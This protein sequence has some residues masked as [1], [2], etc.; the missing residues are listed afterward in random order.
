VYF[1]SGD[2]AVLVSDS[3]E[4]LVGDGPRLC[5]EYLAGALVGDFS[6]QSLTPF[7]GVFRVPA[8]H[9]LRVGDDGRAVLHRWWQPPDTDRSLARADR[10][11]LAENL[12][13]LLA[14]AVSEA[15]TPGPV[16]VELT[17][18]LDS[19]TV[20]ILAGRGPNPVTAGYSFDP[21]GSLQNS[22]GSFID[23]VLARG[24]LT[25]TVANDDSVDVS[26]HWPSWPPP[27][28]TYLGPA[29]LGSYVQ[30]GRDGIRTLLSGWGGD[31]VASF[32]GWGTLPGEVLH[33]HLWR[34]LGDLRG[35]ARFTGHS[36]IR[37]A[38]QQ[39][40]QQLRRPRRDR[41]TAVACRNLC[42]PD[43]VADTGMDRLGP[44]R[45]GPDPDRNRVA[46]FTDG[47]LQRR[48]ELYAWDMSST[49]VSYAYPLLNRDLV[50]WCLTVPARQWAAGGIHRALFRDAIADVVPAAVATRPRK[51]EP[52]PTRA[53]RAA[54][55]HTEVV[56]AV[57][58][59]ATNPLVR[60]Y[61]PQLSRATLHTIDVSGLNH[62]DSVTSF[63][64]SPQLAHLH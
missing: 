3:I 34:A 9:Q 30:A 14:L 15:A 19:S 1:T 57:A 53:V 63:L 42:R 41:A 32:A 62:L 35:A 37:V 6:R 64:V 55:H 18:G 28:P 8:G 31:Q 49:G 12:A 24:G 4:A 27:H 36:P 46:W 11:E 23:A 40:S 50:Q 21:L 25:H 48:I 16:G 39:L 26:A 52:D 56:K 45:L 58:D 5:D 20:A 29:R 60:R 22:E 13:E 54:T 61:L 33:G 59:R 43:F 51:N 38:R 2:G 44:T 47:C 17:G 10:G 7:E